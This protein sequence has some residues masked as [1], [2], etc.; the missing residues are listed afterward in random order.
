MFATFNF[1][2]MDT[3]VSLGVKVHLCI[4]MLNL[5]L[6]SASFFAILTTK[7]VIEHPPPPDYIQEHICFFSVQLNLCFA[8]LKTELW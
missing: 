4:S 5:I 3:Y 2:F 1:V 7:L 8:S 6:T